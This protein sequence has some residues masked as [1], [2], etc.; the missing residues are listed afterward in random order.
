MNVLKEAVRAGSTVL[1]RTLSRKK[2][3]GVQGRPVAGTGVAV[4]VGV[5]VGVGVDV[6]VGVGVALTVGVGVGDGVGVAATFVSHHAPNPAVFAARTWNT[7]V[8]LYASAHLYERAAGS[9]VF[10]TGDDWPLIFS[11][12]RETAAPPSLEGA[13]QLTTPA[14]AEQDA[15]AAGTVTAAAAPFIRGG[16]AARPTTT[17]AAAL[18]CPTREITAWE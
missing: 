18:S 1:S 8:D 12:Y 13:D 6:T 2:L 17:N 14:V 11:T 3:P 9:M 16:T 4:G 10:T 7:D 15:G 5:G